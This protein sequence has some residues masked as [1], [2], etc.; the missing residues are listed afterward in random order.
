MKIFSSIFLFLLISSAFFLTNCYVPPASIMQLT[1]EHINLEWFKGKQVS[2]LTNDSVTIQLSFDRTENN[3]YLF[4]VEIFNNSENNILVNP[5]LFYFKTLESTNNK[6]DSASI[7]NALDPEKAI[8]E[9]QKAYSLHQSNV[10]TQNMFNVFGNLLLLASQTKA[11]ITNDT[12]LEEEVNEHTQRMKEDELL[13][14]VRNEKIERSLSSSK[15]LWET[16]AL[17]KTTLK[18]DQSINGK[19]FFPVDESALKIEFFFPLGNY[20]LNINFVQEVYFK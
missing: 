18:K 19:V 15:Y 8:L 13:D 10:E 14:N 16:L 11:I 12:Y 9:L 4:D 17:R 7:T 20:E 2:T 1:P 3:N 6:R 5:E